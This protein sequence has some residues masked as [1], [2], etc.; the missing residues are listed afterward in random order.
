MM[1]HQ[2]WFKME[3]LTMPPRALCDRSE[4]T[5]LLPQGTPGSHLTAF[6]TVLVTQHTFQL[7]DADPDRLYLCTLSSSFR[8]SAS[9]RGPS[10]SECA[11][12]TQTHSH[13]S[14]GSYTRTHM[15]THTQSHSGHKYANTYTYIHI[16]TLPHTYTGLS[17]HKHKIKIQQHNFGRFLLNM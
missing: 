15:H 8:V 14:P 6:M 12:D 9:Q 10:L 13:H 16:D 5:S 7:K 17:L 11:S 4:L 1:A 3:A 2:P